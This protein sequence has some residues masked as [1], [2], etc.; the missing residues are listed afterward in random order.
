VDVQTLGPSIA[1]LP[2]AERARRPI[3]D[4]L[5]TFG[6]VPLFYYVLHIPLIHAPALV[7]WYLRDGVVGAARFATAPYVSIPEPQQWGL[8]LLYL[9]FAVDVAILYGAC[10]WFAVLKAERPRPW[11]RY[12]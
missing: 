11:M 1:L 9:V 8:P 10:R 6:R 5:V 2:L 7:V 3:A 12:F 4:A